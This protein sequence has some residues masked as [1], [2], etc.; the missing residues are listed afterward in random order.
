MIALGFASGNKTCFSLHPQGTVTSHRTF[1]LLS[2]T[3]YSIH[4]LLTRYLLGGGAFNAPTFSRR[5][6]SE[7]ARRSRAKFSVTVTN[8]LSLRWQSFKKSV[9]FLD[10]LVF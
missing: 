2:A 1:F 9:H 6:G 3:L 7:T 10:M 4:I 8:K 5:H